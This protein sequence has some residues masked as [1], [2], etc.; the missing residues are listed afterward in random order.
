MK[1]I[2]VPQ[3]KKPAVPTDRPEPRPGAG[4]VLVAVAA[5][6]MNPLDEKVRLGEFRQV[7][8]YRAPF[9]LGHDL[10]GTVVELGPGVTAF[11][12]G[13][14]VY[15]RPRDGAVGT[16]AERIVVAVDDLALAPRS[17]SIESAAS[18]PLVAL[19]AWQA[20][21]EIGKVRAGQ[22]VLIH[23]GAGGVGTIA[24]QLAKHLGATVATTA[25]AANAE[26][27]RGLGADIVI[28]YRTESVESVISGYDLVLDSVGAAS[29]A[30]SLRL[31]RPGGIVIGIAGP[32]TPEFARALGLAAPLRL[33]MALLS[34]GVRREAKRLGVS[35]RFLFMHADGAQLSSI[36]ELV[37][38]GVIRPMVSRVIEFD[39][40]PDALATVARGGSRGKVVARIGAQTSDP[41]FDTTEARR[42]R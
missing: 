6:G 24:I 5:S 33:V 21:V 15:S 1:A 22:R 34:R 42:T 8:P 26:F 19:T 20:L 4:E 11:S 12:L 41:E 7:L 18:L 37:D 2:V 29:V 36:A 39:D 27:V 35:Y 14:V 32:P 23:A 13:D 40:I 17:I 38:Q 25:S 3:Y 31:V 10:A 30:T 28:D 16:F 9:I